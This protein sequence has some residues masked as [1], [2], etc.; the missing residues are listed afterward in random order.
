MI[1]GRRTKQTIGGKVRTALWPRRSW[2]RS[3]EYVKKRVLRL[4]A[5]PHAIAAGFAAGVFA[6]FTP[7]MGFH[8]I[9]AAFMAWLTRGSIIAS[10]FGT[11][12]GNPL[13]FPLIWGATYGIG[14]KILGNHG[15]DHAATH[16]HEHIWSLKSLWTLILPMSIGGVIL[17]SIGWLMFYFPIRA[18][19]S[20][21]QNRRNARIAARNG[22]TTQAAE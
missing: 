12:I 11:F 6:S 19:I 14:A 13:T 1:L 18:M 17:G 10:A 20:G 5:T 4:K 16:L 21:Y 9:L 22:A 15:A 2:P 7:L 3:V 8:F